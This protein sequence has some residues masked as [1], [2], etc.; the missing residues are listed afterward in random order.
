MFFPFSRKSKKGKEPVKAPQ[1]FVWMICGFIVFALINGLTDKELHKN[2]KEQSTGPIDENAPD[3]GSLSSYSKSVHS[4]DVIMGSG[5]RAG[6]F[7]EVTLHY[8]LY[9]GDGTLVE[10]TRKKNAPVKFHIGRGEVVPALERGIM[11]MRVGGERQIVAKPGAAYGGLHFSHASFQKDDKAGFV[12]YLEAVADRPKVSSSDMAYKV[13]N[14]TQGDSKSE[15]AKCTKEAHFRAKAWNMRGEPIWEPPAEEKGVIGKGKLPFA[16]EYGVVGMLVGGKRTIIVPPG[17]MNPLLPEPMLE[18]D[19]Q[20]VVDVP[21]PVPEGEAIIVEVEL[22][23][24][25]NPMKRFE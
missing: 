20:A 18:A 10:D 14:D 7:Q 9:K 3:F 8:T 2:V 1:W 22:L 11:G 5:R 21:F 16:L 19:T 13:Y 25:P 24:V 4:K 23:P 6:C 12:V 15:R 17:G